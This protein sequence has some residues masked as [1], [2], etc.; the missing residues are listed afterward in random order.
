MFLQTKLEL[1]LVQA[2][3]EAHIHEQYSATHDGGCRAATK[4]GLKVKLVEFLVKQLLWLSNRLFA[5]LIFEMARLMTGLLLRSNITQIVTQCGNR[6][7][8]SLCRIQL[9]R[10][11]AKFHQ[12]PFSSF[13]VVDDPTSKQTNIYNINSSPT[14]GEARGSVRLLPTKKHPVLIPGFRGGAPVN[15]LVTFR[16]IR[17]IFG[18]HNRP[19]ETAINRQGRY[20]MC[21]HQRVF[22]RVVQQKTSVPVEEYQKLSISRRS[23]QLGLSKST[24]WRILHKDLALKPYKIQLV[25]ELKLTDHS[26]RRRF[27]QNNLLGEARRSV[28]L[29]LT[30]NHP[31]LTPALKARAPITH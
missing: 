29:L 18:Q 9:P 22:D 20:K 28:K 16:K 24:T 27:A 4:H 13:S 11:H 23:Q 21:Q 17:D 25:Q 3:L 15:S 10:H 30:T 5:L 31:V 19:S 14:L 2:L 26:N 1:D 8:Y 7:R 6:T 12:N